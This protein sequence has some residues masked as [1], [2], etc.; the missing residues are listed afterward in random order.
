[1]VFGKPSLIEAHSHGKDPNHDELESRIQGTSSKSNQYLARSQTN[2]TTN[3]A[4]E[5]RRES[6]AWRRGG[7]NPSELTRR[8][9]AK[10]NLVIDLG[11]HRFHCSQ[12]FLFALSLI[13]QGFCHT[14]ISSYLRPLLGGF[15]VWAEWV[16]C[17]CDSTWLF[18]LP[19]RTFGSSQEVPGTL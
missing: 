18:F 8:G 10:P 19:I 11:V 7:S 3:R 16:F 2:L 1:M 13:H 12:S 4:S 14:L 6:F 17:V 15:L 9:C 5:Q